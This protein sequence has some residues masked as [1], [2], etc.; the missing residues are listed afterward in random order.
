MPL[1]IALTSLTLLFTAADAHA[2][3]KSRPVQNGWSTE[4]HPSGNRSFEGYFRN[5]VATVDNLGDPAGCKVM[6]K[7]GD[8]VAMTRLSRG[9]DY[10][11]TFTGGRA[12]CD[13]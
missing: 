2:H 9:R 5:G 4:W 12:T 6:F 7:G 3:S 8:G 13:G 11:C 1:I 10:V